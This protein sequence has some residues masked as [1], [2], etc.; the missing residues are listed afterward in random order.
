MKKQYREV[1][2]TYGKTKVILYHDGERVSDKELWYD[3][4]GDYEDT[5]EAAGYTYG[6]TSDEIKME[7][8]HLKRIMEKQIVEKAPNTRR[9]IL[10]DVWVQYT[11][12]PDVWHSFVTGLESYED[13]EHE[14]AV[15]LDCPTFTMAK[16]TVQD[17][18]YY[19][20][21]VVEK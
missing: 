19:D 16:I 17:T 3:E 7:Q 2:T 12:Q 18:S 10:Y 5:I 20:A 15:A 1:Q 14:L 9:E 13:A 4:V 6:Y 21:K 8:E 11:V